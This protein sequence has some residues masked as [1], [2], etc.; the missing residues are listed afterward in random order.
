MDF[1]PIMYVTHTKTAQ[2]YDIFLIYANIFC[3]FSPKQSFFMQKAPE[4]V[5]PYVSPA[6]LRMQRRIS[7]YMRSMSCAMRCA[8]VS[9]LLMILGGFG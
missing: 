2:R 8:A 5:F 7:E 9:R 4:G 6:S 3:V 1:T